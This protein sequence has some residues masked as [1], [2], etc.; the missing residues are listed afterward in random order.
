LRPGEAVIIH[1]DRDKAML[2]SFS[3]R[4][5]TRLIASGVIELASGPDAHMDRA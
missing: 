2:A 1:V 3:C 4:V 5:G